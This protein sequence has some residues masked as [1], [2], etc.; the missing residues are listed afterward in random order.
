MMGV[1]TRN[2]DLPYMEY[3]NKGDLSGKYPVYIHAFE[4]FEAR[5]AFDQIVLKKSWNGLRILGL[6]ASFGLWVLG[7][8]WARA[9]EYFVFGY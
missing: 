6:R 3:K 4:N 8:G 1:F 5:S 9:Y 7:S 2:Q